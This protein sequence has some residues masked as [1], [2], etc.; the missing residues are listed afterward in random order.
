M[1][2]CLHAFEEIGGR[3]GLTEEYGFLD[4]A[5]TL[6]RAIK[7]NTIHVRHSS[8]LLSNYGRLGPAYDSCVKVIVDKLREAGLINGD[9]A[10][11]ERVIVE[12]V[13]EVCPLLES[14]S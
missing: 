14:Q 3:D 8:T 10:N 9:V 2:H 7:T 12:A 4:V 13:Q 1:T 6:L 5:L 11:M